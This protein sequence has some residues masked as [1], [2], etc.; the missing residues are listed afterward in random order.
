MDSSS[1]SGGA[2]EPVPDPGGAQSP[3][4]FG[5]A[6]RTL[7]ERWAKLAI[8]RMR[9]PRSKQ[10]WK[11]LRRESIQAFECG[12][13]QPAT[14]AE[15]YE[16]IRCFVCACLRGEPEVEVSAQ[17]TR[18]QNAWRQIAQLPTPITRPHV[19]HEVPAPSARVFAGRTAEL[20]TLEQLLPGAPG[21]F[22]SVVITGTA[23][24]GKTTLALYWAHLAA[25]WFPDGQLYVDLH[26]Y[27]DA[28][29]PLTPAAA[30]SQLLRSL[31]VPDEE[32]PTG[33]AELE[34]RFRTETADRQLLLILDNA[35]DASHVR[36][37]LPGVSNS[38]AIITS[39]RVLPGLGAH[40][41][42]LG[43]LDR[44]D[45]ASLLT[46]TIGVQRAAAEPEA[47][48][49]LADLCAR[50][51]LALSVAGDGL[52]A[53][54]AI[55]VS[56]AVAELADERERLDGL[57]AGD[58]AD[59]RRVLDWSFGSLAPEQAQLLTL[60]GLHEAPELSSTIAAVIARVH[61][62][63][64]R[65]LLRGLV[66]ASMIE[67]LPGGRFR[68]HDLLRIYAGELAE[69]HIDADE[70]NAA[71]RGLLQW[72]L[73]AADTTDRLFAPERRRVP[74]QVD[75]DI[76]LP[77]MTNATDAFAWCDTERPNFI[78]I[79]R[80]A[81]RHGFDDVAW[82]LAAT[83]GEYFYLRNRWSEL[84][85]VHEVVLPSAQRLGGQAE[86]WILINLGLACVE[87]DRPLDAITYCAQAIAATQREHDFFGEALAGNN[88]GLAYLK[89]HR[90]D[91]AKD[92][93]DRSLT[94]FREIDVKWGEAHALRNLGRVQSARGQWQE[95][96]DLLTRAGVL[97][98]ETGNRAVEGWAL[99][100][101]GLAHAAAGDWSSAVATYR[102]SLTLHDEVGDR[103]AAAITLDDMGT[104]LQRLGESTEAVHRWQQALAIFETL[105]H[106][107]A[108]GVRERLGT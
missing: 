44:E 98:R 75:Q 76:P 47:V 45:A 41:L 89:L 31:D 26:G 66:D 56:D 97:H 77:A 91:E 88:L 13:R 85:A 10:C 23:G 80:Q 20:A 37:L 15:V 25:R 81:V 49:A 102:E 71:V 27:G 38:R 29:E 11:E 61:P 67:Q 50:L 100:D 30:L 9:D 73:A 92:A 101:V 60:L 55:P 105:A 35:R 32:I 96:V 16:F 72:Y 42:Q 18:W 53:R 28:A 93:L 2:R 106:P 86:C 103:L 36:S 1:A 59:I 58:H 3:K 74:V 51:P 52:A 4:E 64:A 62:A 83:L 8:D 34:V 84:L 63:T 57:A 90:W 24:I 79:A 17:V 43:L 107:R 78:P 65:R 5:Q 87:A 108:T 6:L 69:R 94:L 22:L 70:R 21:G 95:A 33:Q 82:Q 12:I 14:E 46:G 68:F 39:R 99:H 104:A 40:L 48:V 19:P 7:R 54:P